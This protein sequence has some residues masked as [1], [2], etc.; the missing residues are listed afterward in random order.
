MNKT[1][2]SA[3][4]GRLHELDWA[5]VFLVFAVFLHHV[6]MPFNGDGFV[7]MNVDSSKALDDVMVYFEQL[8]LPTLFMVA[9]A[10]AW[11]L[12]QRL[13]AS[14]FVRDK[15]RRL[16]LPLVTGV[17]LIVP[18]Q[19]YF[20]NP[21][22]YENLLVAYPALALELEAMHLWFIEFLFVFFLLAAALLALSN[23]GNVARFFEASSRL[24][25]KPFGPAAMA[26][27]LVVLRVTLKHFWPDED[28]SIE[29]LSVSGFFLFFF[30]TGFVWVR[31]RD[32]WH[33]LG[34]Q[35]RR[36]TAMFAMISAVFYAYY[37]VDLSGVASTPVLWAGWWGLSALVSWYGALT[38]LGVGQRFLTTTPAWLKRANELIYPFYIFHQTV[39]VVLA[40]Y[41]IQW[42]WPWGAKALVLLILSFAGTAILTWLSARFR[43]TR[44]LVGLR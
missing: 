22:A 7:V 27:V 2:S 17:L 18:P 4:S 23:S 11:L 14:A 41:I 31:D 9:G 21:S 25:A 1:V 43:L 40:Y 19:L 39:I 6:G 38:I 24:M 20:E 8:R 36:S 3:Q 15:L 37:F 28:K 26:L 35:W 34:R 5:R 30:L 13:N 42:A 44:V 32:S 33:A 10:G 29:T 16:L 12:L